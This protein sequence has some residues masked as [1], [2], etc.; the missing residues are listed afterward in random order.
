MN[1]VSPGV[2]RRWM[3]RA[4]TVAFVAA[5][6]ALASAVDDAFPG[7]LEAVAEPH[8]VR[9]GVGGTASLRLAD[10]RVEKVR[11]GTVLT[12]LGAVLPTDGAWIMVD[13][14]LTPTVEDVGLPHVRVV[15]VQGR[16]FGQTRGSTTNS[17]RVSQPGIPMSCSVAVELPEDALAGA[18]L[19]VAPVLDPRYDHL[20]EVDLG[21]GADAA[22]RAQEA[23][24]P[25]ELAD[26]LTGGGR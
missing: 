19:Q 4:G 18:V 3:G 1:P 15:D 26:P 16:V 8:L 25:L 21:L 13:L 17:C 14:T 6:L 9:V 23:G 11:L 2:S 22:R 24:D 5:A 7:P 12:S 20:L 10:I